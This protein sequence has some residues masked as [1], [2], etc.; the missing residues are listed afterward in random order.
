MK[1][2]LIVIIGI[3]VLAVLVEIGVVLFYLHKSS[4]LI[5]ET[6]AFSRD[7][8]A[9]RSTCS[10][11]ILILGDSLGIGVGA[12][13]P[14]ES[15]A[16]R[17]AADHKNACI[18][19]IS[20]SGAKVVD[21]KE[22]LKALG[23]DEKFDMI[24]LFGGGNDIVQLSKASDV[25]VDLQLLLLSLKKHSPNIIFTACGN[26]GL[27]PAFIFPLDIFYT[28]RSKEFLGQFRAISDMEGVYFVDLYHEKKEDPFEADPKK[29]Y[30]RD[31]FHPSTSG[32]GIWYEQIKRGF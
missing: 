4:G 1:T 19:N 24:L 16:G 18:K 2:L 6:K 8:A 15:I 13:I 30:A 10:E 25:H 14:E 32:Y 7:T 29:F 17:V 23:A 12:D 11:H 27:A 21:I 28:S 22:Q 20:V 31:G 5:K 26:V 9:D 3:I